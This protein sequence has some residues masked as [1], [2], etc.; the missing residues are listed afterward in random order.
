[1]M[2][3]KWSCGS[4][5]L[6]WISLI[7]AAV[8]G[9]VRDERSTA[10]PELQRKLEFLEHA[11][12]RDLRPLE[13]EGQFQLRA[14]TGRPI[15]ISDTACSGSG[16]ILVTDNAANAVYLFQG[17]H[18]S[19][20]QQV[21]ELTLPFQLQSTD[22]GFVVADYFGLQWRSWDGSIVRSLRL[23]HGM[24]DFWLFPDGET[25]YL[26]P[27]FRPA[28][29][30]QPLILALDRG[31]TVQRGFGRAINDPEVFG[32]SDSLVLEGM[33]DRIVAAYR[34][35]P[36]VAV[37]RLPDGD[38]LHSIEVSHPIFDDLLTLGDDDDYVHPAPGM[39]ALPRFLAGISVDERHIY[40]LLHLPT[41]EIAVFDWSGNETDRWSWQPGPANPLI[42][43][44]GFA[45]CDEG[46]G[47]YF[48]V[49]A[50]T[51]SRQ[52]ALLKLVPTTAAAGR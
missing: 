6:L 14:P 13:L 38:L 50:I 10:P 49:G 20:A 33:A 19:T 2:T 4:R 9:C 27:L 47:R 11:R 41:V 24:S 1:M 3:R 43:Y 42:E 34:Y 52:P 17:G 5:R 46:A 22:E 40:V 21:G 39:I 29:A 37:H 35:Q 15:I 26:N 12:H 16:N 30:E 44:R 32:I 18:D 23:T 45:V 48:L 51:L 7:C 8:L 31:G 36:R 25:I 28:D